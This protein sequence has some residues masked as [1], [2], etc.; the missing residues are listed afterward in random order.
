MILACFTTYYIFDE[1]RSYWSGSIYT[2]ILLALSIKFT[3]ARSER[4]Y[5]YS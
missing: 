4:N 5:V 3:E 2:V 1:N